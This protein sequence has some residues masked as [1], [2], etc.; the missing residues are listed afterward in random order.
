V[1]PWEYCQHHNAGM[2]LSD[3]PPYL[4]DLRRP[5]SWHLG[6]DKFDGVDPISEIKL[7][8]YGSGLN[9]MLQQGYLEG[10]NPI[11]VIG[12]DLGFKG[13]PRDCEEDHDHFSPEYNLNYASEE[14]AK[15]DNETHQ[16]FHRMAYEYCKARGVNI[17]NAGIGGE[18]EAYPRVDYD[19]LFRSG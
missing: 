6:Y 19:T 10:Y 2:V 13:R 8:K 12:C 14:R 17:F 18:L 15:I 1:H 4:P 7:C 11:Y 3:I 16:D 5:E 9:C